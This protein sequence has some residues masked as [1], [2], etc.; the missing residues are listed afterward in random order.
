MEKLGNRWQSAILLP[1]AIVTRSKAKARL[2]LVT[3]FENPR[4]HRHWYWLPVVR[5]TDR[6]YR[7][8]YGKST[9]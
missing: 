9:H 4:H 5:N 8:M 2:S 3:A 6:L 7:V 1:I